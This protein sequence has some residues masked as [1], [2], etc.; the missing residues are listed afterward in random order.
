MWY[1]IYKDLPFGKSFFKILYFTQYLLFFGQFFITIK[2]H[3]I[4]TIAILQ[5]SQHLQLYH[6]RQIQQRLLS[7]DFD[8]IVKYRKQ[9]DFNLL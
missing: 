6:H 5:L 9:K 2:L 7:H 4:Y 3:F 8:A 1:N